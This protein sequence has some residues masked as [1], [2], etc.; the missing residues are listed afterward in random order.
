MKEHG[1]TEMT[2][3][4]ASALFRLPLPVLKVRNVFNWILS[5]SAFLIFREIVV[6]ERNNTSS[7][8]FRQSIP[9][10][11]FRHMRSKSN[12]IAQTFGR[13]ESCST[14]VFDKR[15]KDT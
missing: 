6:R 11:D 8:Q 4:W 1:Y 3:V 2:F 7:A 9:G 10:P 5:A 13:I 14:N 12:R 15:N